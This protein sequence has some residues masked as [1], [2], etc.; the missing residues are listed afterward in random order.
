[1]GAFNNVDLR[2]IQP[3]TTQEPLPEGWYKVSIKKSNIKPTNDQE[4]G[5]LEL[6]CEVIE[7]QYSGRSVY[8][9]LNLWNKSQQS[10]ELSWKQFSAIG[11]CIGVYNPSEGNMPDLAVP[12]FHNIPFFAYLTLF[13]G[14]KGTINQVRG[15][16]DVNG[17]DPGKMANQ[18]SQGIPAPPSSPPQ[19]APQQQPQPPQQG[20]WSAAGAQPAPQQGG[21]APQGQAPAAPPQNAGG[22]APQQQPQ[23]Q[24]APTA[25]PG[26]PPN[27]WSPQQ[28]QP[29]P[30]AA[31]PTNWA[32][33]PGGAAPGGA[34]PWSRPA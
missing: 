32:P 24:A 7:G 29:Q 8:Y 9:N 6:I 34:A 31:A 18:P 27:Q 15:V 3:A 26:P 4:S 1:M 5:K 12:N 14:E 10:A 23:P 11:H 25:P 20:G 22:W 2:A 33:Q 21:W 13:A 19:P 30:P 17:N 28:G 16:K